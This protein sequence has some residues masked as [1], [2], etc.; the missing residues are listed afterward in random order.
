MVLSPEHPLVDTVTTPE[1]K[2]AVEQY[3][4]QCASKSALERTDLSKE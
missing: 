1:Q 2:H 4:A 3:R